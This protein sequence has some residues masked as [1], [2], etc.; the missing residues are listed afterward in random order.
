[1]PAKKAPTALPR[2]P[3]QVAAELRAR[4]AFHKNPPRAPSNDAI[5]GRDF[6]AL[7]AL[8][9]QLQKSRE[10]QGLTLAQLSE[11]CGIEEANL[12]RL[13]SGNAP[14]PTL[15]TLFRVIAALN[16]DLAFTL[17]PASPAGTKSVAKSTR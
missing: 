16:L 6:D 2:T 15:S 3:E 12:S 9:G 4:E 1:M 10:L 7:L 11:R 14:N 5:R 13:L 8:Y 17:T